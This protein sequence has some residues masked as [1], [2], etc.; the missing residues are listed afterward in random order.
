VVLVVFHLPVGLM[1]PELMALIPSLA[2]LLHLEADAAV[3]L[4]MRRHQVGQEGEP[5]ALQPQALLEQPDRVLRAETPRMAALVVGVQA[6]SVVM[7][8]RRSQ[9]AELSEQA[10]LVL[11]LLLLEPALHEV[12]VAALLGIR[13]EHLHHLV[14]QAAGALGQPLWGRVAVLEQLTQAAAGVA[15]ALATAA[16]KAPAELAALAS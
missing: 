14:A 16:P 2:Q 12:E 4:L 11:L 5:V 15:L 6:L 10:G 8:L 7:E 1:P 9:Q 13:G 3:R